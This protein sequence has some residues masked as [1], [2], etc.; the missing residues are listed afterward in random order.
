MNELTKQEKIIVAL[1]RGTHLDK[2][3]LEI[4]KQQVRILKLHIK[5][6]VL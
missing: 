5:N 4:A 6:R 1:M 3:E 2:K